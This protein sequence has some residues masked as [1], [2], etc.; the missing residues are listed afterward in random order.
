MGHSNPLSVSH[1]RH[2]D[3]SP[4]FALGDESILPENSETHASFEDIPSILWQARGGGGKS[5]HGTWARAQC[6]IRCV[7]HAPIPREVSDEGLVYSC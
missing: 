5:M 7:T 6:P 1:C 4:Q 3:S 2:P